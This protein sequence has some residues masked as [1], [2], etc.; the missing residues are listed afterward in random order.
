MQL[1]GDGCFWTGDLLEVILHNFRQN[2]GVAA[3]ETDRH[4]NSV[5]FFKY[6]GVPKAQ[7]CIVEFSI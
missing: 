3:P 1:P 2:S 5:C 6:F 7:K 4:L